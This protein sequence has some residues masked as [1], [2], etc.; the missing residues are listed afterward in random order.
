[1]PGLALDFLGEGPET[2]PEHDADPGRARPARPDG[3][4]GFLN[5]I[6]IVVRHDESGGVISEIDTEDAAPRHARRRCP[7]NGIPGPADPGLARYK[8]YTAPRGVHDQ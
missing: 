5:V 2:G 4:G 3:P 7:D 6:P 1:D 8:G